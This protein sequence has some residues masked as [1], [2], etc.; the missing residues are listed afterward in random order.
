MKFYLSS[1]NYKVITF[2]IFCSLFTFSCEDQVD[3]LWNPVDPTDGVPSIVGDWYSDSIIMHYAAFPD[4]TDNFEGINNIVN[5]NIWIKTDKSFTLSL[6]QTTNIEYQ[7]TEWYGGTWHPSNGCV[8]GQ[9]YDYYYYEYYTFNETPFE[10]CN[11]RIG[12]D[13]YNIS[14]SDCSQDIVVEGKWSEKNTTSGSADIELVFDSFCNNLSSPWG[15]PTYAT[16]DSLCQTTGNTWGSDTILFTPSYSD[17]ELIK[18]TWNDSDT[19][20]V[21]FHMYNAN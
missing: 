20:S 4:S 8:G 6:S 2:S 13:Q 15:L 5:Y 21:V 1:M 18:L 11:D 10:Y 9:G 19:T 7:C 17:N 12:Y 16:T 14:T 3:E